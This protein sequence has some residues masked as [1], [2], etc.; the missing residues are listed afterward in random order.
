MIAE[1]REAAAAALCKA[2]V[3]AMTTTLASQN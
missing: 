1:V 3:A 2:E